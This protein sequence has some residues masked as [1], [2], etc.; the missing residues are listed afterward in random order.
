MHKTRQEVVVEFLFVPTRRGSVGKIISV[1]SDLP[2]P[3][4]PDMPSRGFDRSHS[5][6]YISELLSDVSF[7]VLRKAR[8]N[9][10]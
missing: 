9:F 6:E 4:R 10:G 5:P 1:I 3:T 8:P 7:L 2:T